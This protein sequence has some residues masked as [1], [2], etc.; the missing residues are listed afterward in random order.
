M[1]PVIIPQGDGDHLSVN[2]GKLTSN[3][4]DYFHRETECSLGCGEILTK[5]EDPDGMIHY[6]TCTHALR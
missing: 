5:K 4:D 6:Q 3:L 2:Y 1:L